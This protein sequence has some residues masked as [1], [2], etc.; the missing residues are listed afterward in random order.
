MTSRVER[1]N[2]RDRAVK[3]AGTYL[4]KACG[5]LQ[6]DK[7]LPVT[8]DYWSLLDASLEA[9]E[10]ILEA[11]PEDFFATQPG[12]SFFGLAA[13]PYNMSDEPYAQAAR[14]VALIERRREKGRRLRRI[15]LL[16]A[17]EGRTPEEAAAYRQKAVELRARECA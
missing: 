15:E 12:E 1:M 13:E 6:W 10:E 4:R 2:K 3:L 11:L 14:I 8:G 7:D 9:A 17:V 16:E 5:W